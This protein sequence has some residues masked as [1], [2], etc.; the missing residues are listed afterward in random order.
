MASALLFGCGGA[1]KSADNE[2]A[3]SVTVSESATGLSVKTSTGE[4][5]RFNGSH[6][7]AALYTFAAKIAAGTDAGQALDGTLVL[8]SVAQDDGST[9]LTGKLIGGKL[10]AAPS[11][12]V[13]ALQ[14]EFTTALE[15]L[16]TAYK[17]D[18]E[19]LQA[20][21]KAALEA[22]ATPDAGHR[23]NEAQRAA[24]KTFIDAVKTRT[25]QFKTDSTALV[26]SYQEKV[27]AAGGDASSIGLWGSHGGKQHGRKTV[28]DVTGTQAAD[29]SLTLKLTAGDTVLT[30]TGT[31][32][33]DGSL[34]GTLA[35]PAT[36]DT[37]T[38]QATALF[39]PTP[40]PPSPPASSASG[41]IH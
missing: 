19:A 37:G 33:A 17:T 36:D 11:D 21:L 29:G 40:T 26:T 39:K 15:A 38:W 10:T 16:K 14:A 5:S 41:V 1:D 2:S 12:A 25:E 32:A 4:S 3:A 30:G 31:L 7:E 20:T 6:V 28:Y 18:V 9:A 23:L 8:Q 27:V 13:L 24:I 35:G 34:A 22:A